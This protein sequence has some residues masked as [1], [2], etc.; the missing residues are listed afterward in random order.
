MKRKRNIIAVVS[1]FVLLLSYPNI[2]QSY[3]KVLTFQD[4][5]V[6]YSADGFLGWEGYNSNFN[7]YH[8]ADDF[9]TGIGTAVFAIAKGRVK[10][11][12]YDP[13]DLTGSDW[14]GL[15]IIEHELSNGEK[16]CSIYGHVK[17]VGINV[18]DDLDI[19]GSKIGEVMDYTAPNPDHIHFAIY[20]DSFGTTEGNYPSW[21]HGYLPSSTWPGKYFN[22]LAFVKIGRFAN[23]SSEITLQFVKRYELKLGVPFTDVGGS[24]YVHDWNGIT[25]QNF[26]NTDVNNRYGTD[27]QTALIYNAG[28]NKCW[29]VKEGFWGIYKVGQFHFPNG[30]AGNLFGPVY[31]GAPHEDEHQDAVN[32]DIQ[33]QEFEQCWLQ[34][35]RST[36]AFGIVWKSGYA[37]AGLQAFISYVVTLE[38]NNIVVI[39]GGP[40]TTPTPQAT[41][42]PTPVGSSG[43]NHP[44]PQQPGFPMNYVYTGSGYPVELQF[45]GNVPSAIVLKGVAQRSAA[46][47]PLVQI[48]F[49]QLGRYRNGLV[50]GKWMGKYEVTQ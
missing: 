43:G 20:T 24:I 4:P 25:I 14:L 19:Q 38:G 16:V 40:D 41:P 17:H 31:L 8:V 9:G 47:N 2:G 13:N 23:M 7:G 29:L 10:Y 42:T 36:G 26:Q 11:T 5:V 18:G 22:P 3:E 44:D 15:I 37:P 50:E 35:R 32:S 27:G 49:S 12:L 39:A 28:Q 6:G 48:E 1:T 45:N 46:D 21:G 30:Q 33:T 34:W